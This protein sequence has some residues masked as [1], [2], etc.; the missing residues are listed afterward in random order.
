MLFGDSV[1]SGA[2]LTSSAVAPNAATAR[3][4]SGSAHHFIAT[5]PFDRKH[6]RQQR[7]YPAGA[8]LDYPAELWG[9]RW[10][11]A[12]VMAGGVTAALMTVLADSR[13]TDADGGGR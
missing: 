5:T 7:I 8:P 10:G 2:P 12:K 6:F 1:G 13:H 3:T 4:A 9:Q 11:N